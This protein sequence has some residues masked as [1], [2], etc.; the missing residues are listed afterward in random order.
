MLDI[1]KAM[2]EFIMVDGVGK[3]TDPLKKA[4]NI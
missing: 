2:L 1:S 3:L 4:G